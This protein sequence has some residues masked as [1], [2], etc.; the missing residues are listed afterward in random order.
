MIDCPPITACSD[1]IPVANASDGTL[2][3]VSAKETDKRRAR[4]A[5]RDLQRNGAK[6]MGVCLTKVEDFE[7]K[8]YN[9]YGYGSENK[10]KRRAK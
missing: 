10:K 9:Y 6:L 3:V 1:V 7:Q 4:E 5:V 2:F 8:H